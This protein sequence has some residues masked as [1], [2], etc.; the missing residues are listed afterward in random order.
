MLETL[1]KHLQEVNNK[2]E[3]QYIIF[4]TNFPEAIDTAAIRSQRIDKV[5]EFENPDENIRYDT[6]QKKTRD[7]NEKMMEEN[8]TY[9]F[10][11]MDIHR[12]VD[13]SWGFSMADITSSYVRAI[14][15]KV[16]KAIK[17]GAELYSKVGEADFIKELQNIGEEKRHKGNQSNN[18]I[19]LL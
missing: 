3:N 9:I 12:L 4:A 11:D 2:W 7:Y 17:T 1:M 10:E 16:Y 13:K 5:I 18:K 14:R 8:N 19:G 15:R 6:F